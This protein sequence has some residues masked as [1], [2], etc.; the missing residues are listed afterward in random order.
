MSAEPPGGF[1]VFTSV[2]ALSVAA[3]LVGVHAA[4]TAV[5]VVAATSASGP[6]AGRAA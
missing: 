4:V 2:T 3:G 1:L 5:V 6:V